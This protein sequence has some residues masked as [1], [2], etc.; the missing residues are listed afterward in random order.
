M[1]EGHHVDWW[2]ERLEEALYR[3]GGPDSVIVFWRK[4]VNDFPKRNHYLRRLSKAYHRYNRNRSAI[5]DFE[6]LVLA[7]P[8]AT[9][10]RARLAD[11]YNFRGDIPNTLRMLIS[12]LKLDPNDK[13]A[14]AKLSQM[15]VRI[16]L[17]NWIEQFRHYRCLEKRLTWLSQD[18]H[19][20]PS[21]KRCD[22]FFDDL[23]LETLRGVKGETDALKQ[24]KAV[25]EGDSNFVK[26]GKSYVRSLFALVRPHR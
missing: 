4:L 23:S 24:R 10:F 12:I 11:F 5:H 2:T 21:C 15:Y 18:N 1:I 14:Q 3:R 8:D 22:V 9:I 20:R 17:S 26:R 13:S 7:H 25:V 16:V 6:E 19:G